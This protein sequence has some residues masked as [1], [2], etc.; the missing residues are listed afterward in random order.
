MGS[1]V[2]Q[3]IVDYIFST[4]DEDAVIY[5]LKAIFLQIFAN[6]IIGL[7]NRYL[8]RKSC[9]QARLYRA[10]ANRYSGGNKK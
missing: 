2:T 3:Q 10:V 8:L 9:T 6:Y 4:S 5:K 7:V 1:F